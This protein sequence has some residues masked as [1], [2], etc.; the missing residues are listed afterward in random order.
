MAPGPFRRKPLGLD[1]PRNPTPDSPPGIAALFVIR[2]DIKAGYVISWKRTIPGVE[3][4][5]VVEYKSL[6]SGLHNVSE[7]LVYA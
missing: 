1:V 6:P 5:G 7:D 4:E 2:F 3:I